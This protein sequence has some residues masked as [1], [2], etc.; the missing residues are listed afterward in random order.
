MKSKL[1]TARDEQ[2][3]HARLIA[4]YVSSGVPVPA[5]VVDAYRQAT[6]AFD[7][8]VDGE[9]HVAPTHACPG[10]ARC[11]HSSHRSRL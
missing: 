11:L 1:D 10:A 2:N 4:N 9:Q 8:L 7:R 5:D 6:G 3:R